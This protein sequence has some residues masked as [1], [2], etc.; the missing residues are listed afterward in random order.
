MTN[1]KQYVTING[2]KLYLD[3]DGKPVTARGVHLHTD[4]IAVLDLEVETE[5]PAFEDIEPGIYSPHGGEGNRILR[6]TSAK[7]WETAE[8]ENVSESLLIKIAEWHNEGIL[9]R[10]NKHEA[11]NA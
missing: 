8:G 5:A 10:F 11:T 6:K 2:K 3:E 7:T 4:L 1:R 9:Y